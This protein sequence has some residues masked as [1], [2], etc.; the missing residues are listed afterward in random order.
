MR[1]VSQSAEKQQDI[2]IDIRDGIAR[3]YLRADHMEIEDVG[4]TGGI[5][6]ECAEAFMECPD[7]EAPEVEEVEEDFEA[8]FEY[9]EEWQP[10][11]AKSLRQIQADVEFIAAMTG[12]DLEE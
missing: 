3:I 11:R 7:D 10:G 5:H 8:W 1:C 6:W 9:A 4:E 2:E 12:I